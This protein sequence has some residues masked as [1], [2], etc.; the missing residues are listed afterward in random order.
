ME[1]VGYCYLQVQR[2]R[3]YLQEMRPSITEVLRGSQGP[4]RRS[5]APTQGPSYE[6]AGSPGERL[7]ALHRTHARRLAET[8][9]QSCALERRGEGKGKEG[10]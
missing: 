2:L 6:T 3:L 7:R 4:W 9:A 8:K 5:E 1:I 10:D